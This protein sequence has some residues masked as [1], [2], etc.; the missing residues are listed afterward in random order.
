[1]FNNLFPEYEKIFMGSLM[2]V[3]FVID[4]SLCILACCVKL[5]LSI[6]THI[7]KL[8]WA[9]YLQQVFCRKKLVFMSF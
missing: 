4:Y 1:M 9:D 2:T 6:P 8:C 7:L 5:N 3:N